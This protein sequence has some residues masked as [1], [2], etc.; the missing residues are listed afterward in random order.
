MYRTTWE[1]TR[2]LGAITA[3]IFGGKKRQPRDLMIFPWE[4][5]QDRT[6]E[7]ELIKERRK[8]LGT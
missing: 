2:W 1:Q 4:V 3:N 5:E 7:I 8:W 6:K